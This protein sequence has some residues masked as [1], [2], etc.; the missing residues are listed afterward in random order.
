MKTL[1]LALS[2]LLILNTEASA[3]SFDDESYMVCHVTIQKNSK[4]KSEHLITTYVPDQGTTLM[5]ETAYHFSAT[6]VSNCVMQ[7]FNKKYNKRVLHKEFFKGKYVDLCFKVANG[8]EVGRD[9]YA[10]F[11]LNLRSDKEYYKMGYLN[12]NHPLKVSGNDTV[13]KS[14]GDYEVT[15][16]C[17]NKVLNPVGGLWN[18]IFQ[19]RVK[20]LPIFNKYQ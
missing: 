6:A 4:V 15:A 20:D 16:A 1:I 8:S 10:E 11:Y 19:D 3:A 7:P 12:R 14:I 5:G 2:T 17:E 18:E 9:G 13:T